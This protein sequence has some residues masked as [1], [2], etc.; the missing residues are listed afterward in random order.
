MAGGA[1][2][3]FNPWLFFPAGFH[4][5][6]AG[7]GSVDAQ[8]SFRDRRYKHKMAQPGPL[9]SQSVTPLDNGKARLALQANDGSERPN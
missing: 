6:L 3:A 8:P 4:I 2:R 7:Q 1:F 9:L 5:V